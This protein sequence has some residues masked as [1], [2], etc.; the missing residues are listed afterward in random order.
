[1]KLFSY[2]VARDFGFAP[3]PFY[4][5]C[6]LGTCKPEIRRHAEVGDWVVGTGSKTRG[7]D[8]CI[9]FVMQITEIMSFECYWSDTRFQQKKPNLRGSKKQ[10][11]GDNIY[12]RN[13]VTYE[14]CQLDS[15]HSQPEGIPNIKNIKNDTK[16]DR[17]LIS[18]DYI[19]WGGE[20]P[21]IPAKYRNYCGFDLCKI[22]MGHK[23][24]FPVNMVT[25]FVD[26]IRSLG[27][28]G[29]C[30]TPLDWSKTS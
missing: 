6:T 2:V 30:G 12:Y 27:V 8:R 9:V 16:T 1:M 24:K 5:F 3:N 18:D 28:Q 26:W 19:Y 29:Y 11:F 17:V 23:C 22:G 4:Q 10:A 25:D 7:R 20:G 14:W 15:H 21:Q 13:V